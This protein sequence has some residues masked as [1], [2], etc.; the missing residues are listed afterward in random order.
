M[1]RNIAITKDRPDHLPT[2]KLCLGLGLGLGLALAHAA[3]ADAAP[4]ALE[5]VIL[6]NETF[7]ESFTAIA[8]LEDGS[9]VM[10]Q[11]GISNAGPGD[12]NGACKILLAKPNQ[13]AWT[14]EQLFKD[15]TNHSYQAAP[16]PKLSVGTCFA[17]AGTD[18]LRFVADVKGHKLEL[19]L[20]ADAN[21]TRQPAHRATPGGSFYELEVLVPWA[22]ATVQLTKKGQATQTL[23]GHGYSDHSRATALPGK[24]ASR[25]VRFRALRSGQS[26]LMLVRFPPKGPAVGWHWAQGQ[27]RA[28]ITRAMARKKNGGWMAMVDGKGGPWRI[29]SKEL[30]FRN[31]PLENKGMLG[32]ML[33]AMVGNPVTYTFRGVLES[34][35][36]RQKIPGLFEVSIS[37]E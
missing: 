17:E 14:V 6:S 22:S 27:K 25:W 9:Y 12:R 3:R 29:R 20:Q 19:S 37:D 23:K 5:P 7:T 11:I 32:S 18:A 34:K 13:K 10:M 8:D 35:K 28:N 16:T 30:L 24:T 4:K 21:K 1:N 36:T 15:K 26:Q 31:A 2:L 33:G